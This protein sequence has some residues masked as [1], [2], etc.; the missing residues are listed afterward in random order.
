MRTKREK[1]ETP[2]YSKNTGGTTKANKSKSKSHHS[3]LLKHEQKLSE[4]K[5]KPER[6][7]ALDKK[8][9]NYQK[10]ISKLI[11]ERSRKQSQN[12]PFED[13]SSEI[14]K[15]E[16]AL[17]SLSDTKQTIESGTD[18]ISYLLESSQIIMNYMT[19]EQK[20]QKILNDS[21]QDTIQLNEIAKKKANLIDEYLSKFDPSHVVHRN[22]IGNSEY[23]ICSECNDFYKTANGF[24]VCPSCGICLSNVEANTDLSFKELQTYDYR[25]QFTYEK[26]THL[27]DWL[28][29]FK[30]QENRN[31]P[32][33][34]LDKVLLEVNKER[35][36]DLSLLTEEKVKKY[37]KK[38]DLNEYYDNVIGIINRINGRKPFNLTPEVEDKIKC[39]FQQIQEPYE[40]YKP[41]TRKNF[42]SYSYCLHKL[43]Q[44]LGLHEFSKYFPLLKSDDKLRQQDNIFKKIVAEMAQKDKSVNW[45]FYPSI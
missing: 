23:I 12:E 4:F 15:I 16:V 18:E 22:V 41:S 42:L 13:L 5:N 6:L 3:I 43:F 37:L 9:T 26:K 38:L 35:I 25:P 2:R 28:R 24:L 30:S 1:H 14:C 40:R 33:H 29:R 45:V 27:D 31:I 7:K 20:E 36:S 34:V 32:Q 11:L 21:C 10:D 8:I 19:L 39:M 17:Q 44:I